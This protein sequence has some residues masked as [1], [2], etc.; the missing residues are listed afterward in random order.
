MEATDVL[1]QNL[2]RLR[3]AMNVTQRGAAKAAGLS[4]AGYRKIES[5]ESDPRSDTVLALARA[6]SVPVRDLFLP[7]AALERVRFRAQKKLK[8]REAVLAEVS[9]RLASYAALEKALGARTE[10]SL[11]KPR[12]DRVDPAER[13]AAT[14]ADFGLDPSEPIRD[15]AGLLESRG[16]K[17]LAIMVLSDGFFGLSVADKAV[18]PA[19]VV[20]CAARISVERRI[21]TAAHELGHLLMHLGSY[22]VA[23]AREREREEE[24]ADAFASHFLMPEALFRREW[25]AAAGLDLVNRVLKVKRIFRV[26][27]RTV[28]YRAGGGDLFKRFAIAYARGGGSLKGHVEPHA[29]ASRA[30][31]APAGFAA[32]EPMSLERVD[33]EPERLPRLV[34]DA[35]Q[36]ECISVSRAAEI[37]EISLADIRRRAMDWS[38]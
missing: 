37:L 30:P 16:I 32:E 6:L 38:R 25:D 11:P 31:V 26:S 9:R 10:P 12:G 2:K 1:P 5:G 34:R 22:E 3:S 13:A 19:V 29:I 17:V 15:I 35:L 20:N 4:L 8:S 33:F 7:V 21:F 14:R 23:D 27:Y 36:A 18:G 24:E 28:L